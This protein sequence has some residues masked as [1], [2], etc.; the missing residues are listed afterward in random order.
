MHGLHKV[1]ARD[2][3]DPIIPK[4]S[5]SPK[6]GAIRA[7]AFALALIVLGFP[8]FSPDLFWHLS[9]GRWI[10][11]HLRVPRVDP[12]SFTAA[13]VPWIDFEWLAQLLLYGVGLTGGELGLWVLK[14]ILLI[15]AFLPVDG[16]LRERRASPLARAGALALWTAAMVPQADLRVDLASAAFFAWLL[17][18]LDSG[19]ASF[20]FGFGLF[21]LW[22]NLHAGFALGFFLYAL[23]ALAP[24]FGGG[25]PI[26]GIAAE[27]AGAA[28]GSL[29]NPYGLGIYRVLF[30][31]ATEPA[32]AR[33][34]MEW[35]PPNWHR[36]FQGPLLAARAVTALAACWV[37]ERLPRTL[38]V[39]ALALGL[40][41]AVSARFG[42]YFASAGAC[43]VFVAFPRPRSGVLAAGLAAL[44]L[45]LVP[46]LMRV[47]WCASFQDDYVARRAVE[48]IVR[49]RAVL[50]PLRLFNQYEWGGYLGWRMG[51][52]YKVFGDGRYL[53][54]S[55]L[56]EVQKALIAGGG[57]AELAERRGL[58][59][60]LMKNERLLLP[61]TRVYPDGTSRE[62]AR[63]WYVFTFPRERWALVY[64]DDQALLFLDR[65]KA[66]ATWLSEHE[67]RWLRPGDGR[68]L[69]DAMSRGEVPAA[70]LEAERVRHRAQ[71]AR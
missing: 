66:P 61:S 65:A 31:H 4:G 8:V 20:L 54:H 33:F 59:G 32:M 14:G 17:R 30:A 52:G 58:V 70:A 18:R 2:P 69:E 56:P 1:R 6:E 62:I 46:P 57:I 25:K 34:V 53:F 67:Y 5:V 10:L 43:C 15:A 7:W 24:R 28:L 16:L 64:W 47:R 38:A 68:A 49:E 60:F 29:L 51:E 9:S 41:T 23:Y 44:S 22:S 21:V 50:E 40:A 27:A 3:S 26:E 19:R 12:F 39:A 45:M 48:F 37:R 42:A 35:G 71:T 36:A 63:P 13:G 55:Q 11:S